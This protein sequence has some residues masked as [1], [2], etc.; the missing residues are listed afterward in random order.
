MGVGVGCASYR[1]SLFS[2]ELSPP[3]GLSPCP[4]ISASCHFAV[5]VESRDSNENEPLRPLTRTGWGPERS[6]GAPPRTTTEARLSETKAPRKSALEETHDSP[7]GMPGAGGV[8]L[9]SRS[10]GGGATRPPSH[11]FLSFQASSHRRKDAQQRGQCPF[12]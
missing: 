9:L 5:A 3:A 7:P 11:E 6:L 2:Q 4:G 1:G 10:G 12:P 8:P